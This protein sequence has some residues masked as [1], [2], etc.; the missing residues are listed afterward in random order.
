MDPNK[1]NKLKATASI[2][3]YGFLL[4]V[5]VLLLAGFKTTFIRPP[6]FNWLRESF[7]EIIACMLILSGFFQL[8]YDDFLKHHWADRDYRPLAMALIGLVLLIF[9]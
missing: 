5:V 7:L 3:F 9:Y 1:K 4:L 8:W 2:V 6:F